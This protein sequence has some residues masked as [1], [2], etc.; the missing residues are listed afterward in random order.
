MV[1][2]IYDKTHPIIVH[3]RYVCALLNYLSE[4]ALKQSV[5]DKVKNDLHYTWK[6]LTSHCPHIAIHCFLR[7]AGVGRT[8]TYIAMDVL[9]EQL[10]AESKIDVKRFVEEM[11]RRRKDMV[12]T[13]VSSAMTSAFPT[14]EYSRTR[15]HHHPPDC[16]QMVTLAEWSLQWFY[17]GIPMGAMH[18]ALSRSLCFCWS[19]N[20]G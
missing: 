2:E 9:W 1:E 13:V 3:C 16:T 20:R 7:S 5:W 15:W 14:Y 4:M 17:P 12:Q 8:G 19:R 18:Y 11:R 10:N 6:T